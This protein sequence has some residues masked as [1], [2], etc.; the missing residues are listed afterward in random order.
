[1]PGQSFLR[2]GGARGCR[3]RPSTSA[4]SAPT[5]GRARSRSGVRH[6]GVRRASWVS[7]CELLRQ[8]VD[9]RLERG[10]RLAGLAG[11]P[12][13]PVARPPPFP[14]PELATFELLD[15][16]LPAPAAAVRTGQARS[17]GRGLGEVDPTDAD[18]FCDFCT[19]LPVVLRRGLHVLPPAAR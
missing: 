3:R 14:R 5:G 11:R 15:E 6:G 9:V 8:L 19:A 17:T 7:P 1:R 13:A 2:R 18:G 16:V 4:A 12:V 10:D